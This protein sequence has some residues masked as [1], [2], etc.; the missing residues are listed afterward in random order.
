L[1][2]LRSSVAAVLDSANLLSLLEVSA[3]VVSS[4]VDYSSASVG[5]S[6]DFFLPF[7]K[8]FF[9]FEKYL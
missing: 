1:D 2:K 7:L 6:G 9:P 3:V 5:S 8:P 4:R